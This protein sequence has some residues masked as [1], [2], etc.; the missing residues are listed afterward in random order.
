MALAIPSKVFAICTG[1]PFFPNEICWHCIYPIKIGGIDTN[2]VSLPDKP[3]QANNPVCICPSP[4]F[5]YRTGISTAFW[6]PKFVVETVK[7]PYCFPLI[8]FG[9]GGIPTGMGAGASSEETQNTSTFA[10]VHFYQYPVYQMLKVFV[11]SSCMDGTSSF[12]VMLTEIDPFW[13]DDK[14]TMLSLSAEVLLFANPAAQIACV[15]DSMTSN[16]WLPTDALYWCMGSWGSTYPMTGHVNDDVYVQANAAAA[17]KFIYRQYRLSVLSSPLL[18][19][20]VFEMPDEAIDICRSH[21]IPI[22]IKS[23]HRFQIGRPVRGGTC[24]PIGRSSILWGAG[25]NPPGIG[26]NF[27]WVLFTKKTCCAL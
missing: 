2:P 3:D 14:L 16:V 18:G 24:F 26:D 10:Q 25:K 19:S 5:G 21:N 6:Q 12:N 8:G 13:K 7:D 23:H 9:M 20:G 4:I 22:W 15:A 27:L 11:D 17:A 1:T